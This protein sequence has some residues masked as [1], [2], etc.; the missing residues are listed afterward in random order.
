MSDAHQAFGQHVHQEPSDKLTDLQ[1]HDLLPVI[2]VVFIAEPDLIVTHV[3]QALV[4]DGDTM[5]VSGEIADDA[6]SSIQTVLAI[7]HPVFLHQGV[8]HLVDLIV[9]GDTTK[10]SFGGAVSQ[11]ADQTAPVMTR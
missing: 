4:A 3:D 2:A 11:C 1:R 5:G 8:E 6:V 9:V 10:L 7:H